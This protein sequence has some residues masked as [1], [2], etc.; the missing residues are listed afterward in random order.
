MRGRFEARSLTGKDIAQE[1]CAQSLT[2]GF[3]ADAAAFDADLGFLPR[4]DGS[5]EITVQTELGENLL[6]WAKQLG[7][8]QVKK[9]G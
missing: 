2:D 9:I 3:H 4:S 8:I 7:L 1:L 6:V 5:T